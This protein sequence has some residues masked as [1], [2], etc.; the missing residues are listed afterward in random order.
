MCALAL[1]QTDNWFALCYCG[2]RVVLMTGQKVSFLGEKRWR[3]NKEESGL[4]VVKIGW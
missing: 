4:G 3:V 1:V 2:K